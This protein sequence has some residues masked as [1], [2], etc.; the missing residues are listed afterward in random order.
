MWIATGIFW[1]RDFY[2]PLYDGEVGNSDAFRKGA[3]LFNRYF[4]LLARYL[5]QV[6]SSYARGM[7]NRGEFLL[8][9]G[10]AAKIDIEPLAKRVLR[11]NNEVA[12]E[13][14]SA[15]VEFPEVLA[16]Y[17]APEFTVDPIVRTATVNVALSGQTLAGSAIDPNGDAI[18]FSKVSGPSWLNVASNGALS[19][20]P[21]AIGTETFTVK[22]ADGSGFYTESTLSIT[23]SG[24]VCSPETDAAFCSRLSASC[25]SKTAVDNCNVTRTVASC[26]TCTSPQICGGSGTP[27]VCGTGSTSNPC[28]GLCSSPISFNQSAQL[29]LDG[30]ASCHETTADLQGMVCGGSTGRT[31][32]VNGTLIN[33]NSN[34]TLPAKRNGGYCTQWSAGNQGDWAYFSTW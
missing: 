27:N 5:P 29:N 23:V 30:S 33:C 13:Y 11:W 24:T 25:G 32:K 20:T 4:N 19:G 17:R 31:F 15:R 3:A 21:N 34:I 28:A 16:L 22:V 6:N 8:F 12:L 18:T 1:F 14:E 2:Y 9:M 7:L 10:A 26:G